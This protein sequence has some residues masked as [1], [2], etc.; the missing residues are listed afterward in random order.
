[1]PLPGL[2]ATQRRS[3]APRRRSRNGNAARTCGPCAWTRGPPRRR[4]P[5]SDLLQVDEKGFEL[6]RARV[7]VADERSQRVGGP[8]P[9]MTR[10]VVGRDP[11][12]TPVDRDADLKNLLPRHR[13]RPEPF[14]HDGVDL[15]L[16][17]LRRHTH[18]VAVAD[19]LL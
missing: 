13:H 19:A 4:M 12:V 15:D 3:R 11:D 10:V 7:R 9:A 5:P 18:L 14:G 6:G 8:V 17:A 2:V 1:M 16:A